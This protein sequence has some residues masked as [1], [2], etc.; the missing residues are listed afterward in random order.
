MSGVEEIKK[1]EEGGFSPS[2]I[3]A[4]KLDTSKRLAA[5]GFSNADIDKYFGVEAPLAVNYSSVDDIVTAGFKAT[6]IG[7]EVPEDENVSALQAFRRGTESSIS[8]MI[9]R[10]QAGVGIGNDEAIWD[11]ISFGLGEFLGDLPVSI[12]SFIAGAIPGA[13]AGAPTG[14]AV[15]AGIGG[16]ATLPAGGVG[17]APG[18]AIGAPVGAVV[19]AGVGGGTTSGFVTGTTRQALMQFYRDNQDADLTPME[20]LSRFGSA[21]MSKDALAQGAFEAKIGAALGV[22]GPVGAKLA[23]PIVKPITSPVARSVVQSGIVSSTE[24]GATVGAISAITGEMPTAESFGQAA[25][26]IL[27]FKA[28]S[29]AFS[30]VKGRAGANHQTA[31]ESV[32]TGLD[33]TIHKGDISVVEKNLQDIY[34]ATGEHPSSIMDRAKSDADLRQSLMT[35]HDKV[36]TSQEV[37]ARDVA[38]PTADTPLG[39]T[40]KT[41][42]DNLTIHRDDVSAEV[43]DRVGEVD[44]AHSKVTEVRR[45]E[46][47]G[48]F[49]PEAIAHA[50]AEKLKLVKKAEPTPEDVVI[51]QKFTEAEG[52]LSAKENAQLTEFVSGSSLGSDVTIFRGGTAGKAIGTVVKGQDVLSTSRDRK[53]AEGFARINSDAK[54]GDGKVVPLQEIHVEK[55]ASAADIAALGTRK[56]E[57]EVLIRAED[58]TN[59]EIIGKKRVEKGG[60]VFEVETIRIK[61]PTKDLTVDESRAVIQEEMGL[62][63]PK[64]PETQIEAGGREPPKEPPRTEKELRDLEADKK[65]IGD[66]VRAEKRRH[67]SVNDFRFDFINDLQF[68]VSEAEGAFRAETGTKLSIEQN[69]GELARLAAG[70]HAQADLNIRKGIFDAKGNKVSDG[71]EQIIDRVPKKQRTDFRDY[72][73]AKRMVEKADQ[74]FKVGENVAAARNVAKS[75][76]KDPAFVK[77]ANEIQHWQDSGVKALVESGLMSKD[78]AEQMIRLNKD[79]VPF[80]RLMY[81]KDGPKGVSSRGIPVRNPVKRFK[82]SDLPLLDPIEVMV[83]NRYTLLQMAENNKARQRLI[84]FNAKLSD[85]NQ[86]ISRV[87]EIKKP[88][89]KVTDLDI[90]EAIPSQQ[91]R[92]ADE[93]VA[94]DYKT[95]LNNNGMEARDAP[96][97]A[98]FYQRSKNLAKDEFIVYQDGRP[99]VYKAR[100]PDLVRSL[101]SMTQGEQNILIKFLSVPSAMMRSGTVLAPDFVIRATVR[102]NF[103]S[104]F[105]NSFKVV[106]IGDA[107]IGVSSIIKKDKDYIKWL[108]SGGANSA[109]LDMDRQ[110]LASSKMN[111][112]DPT[113]AR[114]TWNVAA[115]PYRGL[116]YASTMMENSMRLGQF[117]RSVKAGAD[118]EVAALRSRDVSLDFHR[119]GIRI[120]QY[121]RISA[122]LGASINGV[123]RTVASFKNN[124]KAT[125]IKATAGLTVPSMI[126][127]ALN[128]D[129]QWYQDVPEWEKASYWHFPVGDPADVENFKIVRMP[130]PLIY[131]QAFGYAPV[132]TLDAYLNDRPEDAPKILKELLRSVEVNPW[133]TAL[134]PLVEV[135]SNMNFFTQRPLVGR[136]QEAMLPQ[137]RYTPYTTE[138]AKQAA[139][140]LGEWAGAVP[141]RFRTPIALEHI[142]G[143]WSGSLGQAALATVDASLR[144]VGAV[145]DNVKPTQQMEDIPLFRSFFSRYPSASKQLNDFYENAEKMDE[146][147]ATVKALGDQGRFAEMDE[148]LFENQELLFKTQ[149][150]K[151]VISR[152]QNLIRGVWYNQQMTPDEKRQIIDDT[153][154]FMNDT[155]R[156]YNEIFKELQKKQ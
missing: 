118:L 107:I 81:E 38:D 122:F 47:E 28:G 114:K 120:R 62:V 82:G 31:N 17:A 140:F 71:L 63:P 96:E 141:E 2:E 127:Y 43:F 101:Q 35:N 156:M 4:W 3:N 48:D 42:D 129:E 27:T 45:P 154:V 49:T 152:Q 76:D 36:S 148:I 121:N 88:K 18:A 33:R 97:F 108:N 95:W 15:G 24:I 22:A 39:E 11:Q 19:G 133:P 52:K 7:G 53:I 65:A 92:P 99:V 136:A 85:E 58:M 83:K 100:N 13:A 110:I 89:D 57:G 145:P 94:G 23:K 126:L 40:P 111:G 32:K 80:F 84:E 138:T 12:P 41:V 64:A 77:A 74:G 112:V 30:I 150:F 50:R 21:L 134:S 55:G 29:K 103:S 25:T 51:I 60:I 116:A 105:L 54:A 91:L 117:K 72:L 137:Y 79:Y 153:L 115:T 34:A 10:G 14:A 143:A 68:M 147:Q 93:A 75:G 26:M 46:V 59:A 123:D 109:L 44:T 20:F 9:L 132:A 86:F 106:P 1:L 151:T 70:S 5:G 125:F 61:K 142:I 90:D 8:G 113:F 102:D 56:V 73:I 87:G 149:R 6:N 67:Y 128:R 98:S 135:S 144:K 155:A 16:L 146:V 124:P 104:V 139:K 37:M 66:M 78:R 130:M 131:G 119:M 69:P